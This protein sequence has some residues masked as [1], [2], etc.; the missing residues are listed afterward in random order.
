SVG[1]EN[2]EAAMRSTDHGGGKRRG[3]ERLRDLP[4]LFLYIPRLAMRC[5]RRAVAL[6][7][8]STHIWP[9]VE[10]HH[11]ASFKTKAAQQNPPGVGCR[12]INIV[13]CKRRVRA[14]RRVSSSV[15]TLAILAASFGANRRKQ[16]IAC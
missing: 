10:A 14:H 3:I 15:S 2:L 12:W 4:R 16:P 8:T 6:T 7:H 13:T 11:E 9:K 5:S 1:I